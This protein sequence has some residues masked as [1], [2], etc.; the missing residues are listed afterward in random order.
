MGGMVSGIASTAER[1]GPGAAK[2]ASSGE[3]VAAMSTLSKFSAVGTGVMAVADGANELYK[4]VKDKDVG[5]GVIGTVKAGAGAAMLIGVATGQPEVVVGGAIV[6]AGAEA[7][8]FYRQHHAAINKAVSHGAQVVEHV[9][10]QATHAAGQLA[11]NTLH[12][13][14]QIASNTLHAYGDEAKRDVQA[15]S[16]VASGAWHWL[17]G[18]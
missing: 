3:G 7:A 15:M 18:S 1:F 10:S 14:G 2:L 9:A 6:Y 17:S 5:E 16:S 8:D 12:A 13:A 4:G 11:T